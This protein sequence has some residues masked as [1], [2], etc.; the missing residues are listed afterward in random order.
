MG[1]GSHSLRIS[2]PLFK[3]PCST[4]FEHTPTLHLH[5]RQNYTLRTCANRNHSTIS[6][7]A[8]PASFLGPC[9]WKFTV[10]FELNMGWYN[11]LRSGTSLSMCRIESKIYQQEAEPTPGSKGACRDLFRCI[12]EEICRFVS[13]PLRCNQIWNLEDSLLPCSNQD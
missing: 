7:S 4:S 2:R 1:K 8:H 5:S 10:F 6:L 11:R 12:S 3:R 13:D 9:C